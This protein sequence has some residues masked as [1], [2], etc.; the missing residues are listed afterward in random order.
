MTNH[1]AASFIVKSFVI[2]GELKNCANCSNWDKDRNECSLYKVTPP[3][4]VILYGCGADWEMD[5][6]F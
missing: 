2:N 3:I 6:P 4:E 1:E 5:I